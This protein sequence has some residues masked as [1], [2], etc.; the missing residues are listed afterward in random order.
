[1]GLADRLVEVNPDA[2]MA[3]TDNQGSGTKEVEKKLL[4]KAKVDTLDAAAKLAGE[5][6]EGGPLALRGVIRACGQGAKAEGEEYETVLQSQ[7]RDEALV[8]FREKR[9]PVYKGS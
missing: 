7:D 3:G 9:K 2:E 4:G 8:A 1:M 6:C 5:I